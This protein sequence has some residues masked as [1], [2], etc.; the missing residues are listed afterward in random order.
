MSKEIKVGDTEIVINDPTNKILQDAQMVY[1]LK[2]AELIKKAASGH[3][4]LLL[5]SQL[6]EY[7][8][9]LGI[10]TKND[11][12]ELITKQIELRSLEKL[13][14]QGGIKLSDGR[15]IAV[16]MQQLR[17][18][19]M[20]LFKKRSQFDSTTIEAQ[21]DQYKFIHVLVSTVINRDTEVPYF[22]NVQDYLNREQDNDSI[23]IAKN[24]A[25]MFFGYDDKSLE[26]LPENKWLKDYK[27]IDNNNRLINKDGRF[28]DQNGKLIDENGRY[29]DKNGD[30]I[31]YDGARVDDV[32]N[33]IVDNPKPFIDDETNQ[34]VMVR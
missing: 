22:I 10:W 13:L 20:E 6:D 34:E 30:F 29:I 11:G 27:F 5:K 16:R 1:N 18:D 23:E 9:M 21:A 7:L 8:N 2:M 3:Q 31:D 25:M 28:V 24:V 33:L 14:K 17:N 19:L 12:L 4:S 32:G 15:E 26:S